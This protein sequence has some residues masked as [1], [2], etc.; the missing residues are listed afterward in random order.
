MKRYD[1]NN[2]RHLSPK[3][4]EQ[5]DKKEPHFCDYF[6][7][8]RHHFATHKKILS[9][10]DCSGFTFEDSDNVTMP[11]TL[12]AENG[13]KALLMGEFF[14]EVEVTN[15]EYCG[16]GACDF[17]AHYAQPPETIIIKVPVSW[18]TIKDIYKMAVEGLAEESGS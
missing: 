14:E 9:P 12:T 7:M 1:C 16:C 5:T 8:R 13:A 2:C 11:K 17:C 3:E 10:G 18:T 4:S 6:K 15:P